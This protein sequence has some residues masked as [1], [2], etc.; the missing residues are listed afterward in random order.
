LPRNAAKDENAA[1]YT[2]TGLGANGSESQ[3]SQTPLITL[4]SLIVKK[5]SNNLA[6]VQT[7]LS[8]GF[9]NQ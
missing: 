7:H 9:L 4:I 8:I 6:S 5:T 2:R 3:K 1:D